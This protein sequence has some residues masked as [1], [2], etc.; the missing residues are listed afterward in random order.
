MTKSKHTPIENWIAVGSWV[1]NMDD[2]NADICSCNP[3]DFGQGHME[4]PTEEQCANAELIVHCVT[5][6]DEL[7]NEMKN[8]A[9]SL[10]DNIELPQSFYDAIA[11]AEGRG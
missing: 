11:K 7:L 4:M 5:M 1:E 10:E 9:K 2:K 8:L 3:E 6:H